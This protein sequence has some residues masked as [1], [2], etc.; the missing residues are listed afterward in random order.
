MKKINNQIKLEECG[1]QLPG[2]EK[3]YDFDGDFINQTHENLSKVSVRDRGLIDIRG[4]F[5]FLSKQEALKLY[6]LAYFCKNDILEI[7]THQG[8]SSFIMAHAL[9]DS[10]KETKVFTYDIE[11]KYQDIAVAN[12]ERKKFSKYVEFFLKDGLKAID[13]YTENF[14]LVFIDHDHTY[15]PNVELCKLLKTV[16]EKGGF[17]CFHDYNDARNKTGEYGIWQAVNEAIK[18]D[19]FT[20]YGIYGSMAIY[21]KK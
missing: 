10:N 8:L 18:K 1:A 3:T 11:K 5:G 20:F 17:V 16:V 4:I 2:Y 21:R 12:I 13:E 14:G 19:D 7:G 15:Q 9:S 6:E